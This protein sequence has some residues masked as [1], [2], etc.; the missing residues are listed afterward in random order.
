MVKAE[1]GKELCAL[2]IVK[3]AGKTTDRGSDVLT[4]SLISLVG[5]EQHPQAK[6]LH[7]GM[8][9]EGE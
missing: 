6:M 4:H 7:K 1:G 9:V 2:L 5:V 8:L 3:H